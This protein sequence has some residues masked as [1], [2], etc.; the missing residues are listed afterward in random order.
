MPNRALRRA[1]VTL[2]ASA[3]SVG[4]VAPM[5][6]A[7]ELKGVRPEF[8]PAVPQSQDKGQ[9]V[10]DIARQYL[11][12]PYRWGGTTPAGF[13]CSGFTQYVYAKAGISLPRTSSQQSTVGYRVS[14]ANARPGDLMWKPGHV[15]I[16]TGNGKMIH[17]P[18]SGDVVKEVSV[19]SSSFVYIRVV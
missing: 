19:Y 16:Y 11:G 2:A 5:A 14:A 1:T 9:Q 17:S 6:S 13:D 3:L 12:V 10:V 7:Y 15:G 18:S 4:V 8:A